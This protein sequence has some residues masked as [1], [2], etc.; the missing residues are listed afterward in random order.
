MRQ[1]L[2][3]NSVAANTAGTFPKPKRS[4][5]AAAW[6]VLPDVAANSR[7]KVPTVSSLRPKESTR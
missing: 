2:A 7:P 1:S 5:M 6:M 3:L 4:I